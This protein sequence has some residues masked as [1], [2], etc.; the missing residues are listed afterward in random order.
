MSGSGRIFTPRS[1]VLC[2]E[3]HC[4]HPQLSNPISNSVSDLSLLRCSWGLKAGVRNLIIWACC[5]LYHFFAPCLI[6]PIVLYFVCFHLLA[7][8]NHVAADSLMSLTKVIRV[9]ERKIDNPRD[10]NVIVD[11][12]VDY[13][14]LLPIQTDP[15]ILLNQCIVHTFHVH[16]YSSRLYHNHTT[17][18]A[19]EIQPLDSAV[20]LHVDHALLAECSMRDVW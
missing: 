4:S 7:F 3:M 15:W 20:T 16:V 12:F 18:V 5:Q 13:I 10:K 11:V 2:A 8:P 19:F 1:S 9:Q 17:R 6:A 14:N